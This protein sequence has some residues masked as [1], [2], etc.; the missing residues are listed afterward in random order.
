MLAIE[1]KTIQII[2]LF[3]PIYKNFL[4]FFIFIVG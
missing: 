1:I 3:G 2:F 4:N